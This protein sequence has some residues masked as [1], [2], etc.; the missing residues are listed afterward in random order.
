MKINL[1][2][3]FKTLK[4]DIIYRDDKKTDPLTLGEVL[5]EIV[6][7]PH[8]DKKGF[9]PLKGL[10]LARKFYNDKEIELDQ[11]DFIQLKE[12]IEESSAY[13]ALVTGQVLE[14]LINSEKNSS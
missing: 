14:F 7:S 11:S 9:R 8:R 5:S 3:T 1:K 4:G 6:L 2:Q 10:E 12:I 13:I